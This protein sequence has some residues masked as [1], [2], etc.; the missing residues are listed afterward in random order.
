MVLAMCVLAGCRD[1]GHAVALTIVVGDGV[2]REAISSL[3]LVVAGDET[4]FRKSIPV[5]GQLDGGRGGFL[6]RP[7]IR[8]GTLQ[9][10]V[11]ALDGAGQ[12]IAFGTVGVT[13]DPGSTV[14]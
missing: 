9:F 11:S 6:Y 12:A 8:Q 7:L 5:G 1:Y 2:D 10:A 4:E 14:E 3:D 13:L